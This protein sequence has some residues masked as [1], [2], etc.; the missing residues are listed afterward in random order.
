M[1]EVGVEVE[2]G[3]GVE[4][5]SLVGCMDRMDIEDSSVV[6]GVEVAVGVVDSS[7]HR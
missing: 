2:V 7:H 3:V 4:G 1:V 6:V 5:N